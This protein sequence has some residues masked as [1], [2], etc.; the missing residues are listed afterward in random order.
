MVRNRGDSISKSPVYVR[1]G[2]MQD[3]MSLGPFRGQCKPAREVRIV[4]S[5]Y[6]R[7]LTLVSYLSLDKHLHSA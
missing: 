1:V 3:S 2:G 6:M 4:V 5:R 7:S